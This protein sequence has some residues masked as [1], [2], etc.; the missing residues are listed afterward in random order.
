MGLALGDKMELLFG[1]PLGRA[2]ETTVDEV[3]G[4]LHE[5][6]CR[7]VNLQLTRDYTARRESSGTSEPPYCS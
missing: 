7:H 2:A 5:V 1:E 4:L 3:Q 6:D